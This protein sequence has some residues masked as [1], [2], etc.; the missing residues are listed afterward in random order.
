MRAFTIKKIPDDVHERLRRRAMARHRSLNGEIIHILTKAVSEEAGPA[1][2]LE[3]TA[4]LREQFAGE[5]SRDEIADALS[6]NRP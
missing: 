4:A 1:D 2:L 6:E 5:L 3:R